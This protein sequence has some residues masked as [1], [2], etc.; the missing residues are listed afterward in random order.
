M[1]RE[2]ATRTSRARECFIAWWN[3]G[4]SWALK[5]FA[6]NGI[7]SAVDY[8]VLM[9]AA[10]LAHLPTAIAA[11][12]GVAS[13]A[14]FNFALNRRI[15][16]RRTQDPLLPQLGRYVLAIGALMLVHAVAMWL[17]RDR[18]GLPILVSKLCADLVILA[19][20][21]P[22]VLRRFVFSL[23]ARR[24]A[25]AQRATESSGAPA[26]GAPSLARVDPRS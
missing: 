8:S 10:A 14:T 15:A 23:P 17:L 11:M 24:G 16:F 4:N 2:P 18:L 7:G 26:P 9:L 3:G 1:T 5:S 19:G 20:G 22:F 6:L 25:L 12:F 21:Q 13:G